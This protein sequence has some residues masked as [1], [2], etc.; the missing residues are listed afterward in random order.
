MMEKNRSGLISFSEVC[1]TINCKRFDSCKRS[2]VNNIG[3]YYVRSYGTEGHGII[4]NSGACTE[5]LCGPGG[6]YKLFEPAAHTEE[7]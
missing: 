2:A 7:E 4:D 6:N 5:S 3:T 1:G